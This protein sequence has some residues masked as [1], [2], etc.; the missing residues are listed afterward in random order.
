LQRG[1]APPFEQ[2]GEIGESPPI[3]QRIYDIESGG[4]PAEH[5]MSY[6]HGP[7]GAG[8]SGSVMAPLLGA[9]SRQRRGHVFDDQMLRAYH[10]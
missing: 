8:T 9:L 10:L 4:V 7:Y 2:C 5:D 1:P 6:S 3:D